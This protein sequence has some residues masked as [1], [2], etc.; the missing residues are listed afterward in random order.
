MGNNQRI[1]KK[2]VIAL[3]TKKQKNLVVPLTT[4]YFV[5]FKIESL[6]KGVTVNATT[7][8]KKI[9]RKTHVYFSRSSFFLSL[10]LYH[11]NTPTLAIILSAH[12]LFFIYY[13]H[14]SMYYY[15]IVYFATSTKT[16]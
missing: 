3:L 4:Y 15:H 2:D 7:L 11:Y 14:F 12:T 5:R 1:N 13:V 9:T 16:V 8:N 10:L 6:D